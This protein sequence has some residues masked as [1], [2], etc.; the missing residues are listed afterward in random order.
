MDPPL[1]ADFKKNETVTLC[2]SHKTLRTY[3]RD[4][5]HK[6]G[7]IIDLKNVNDP[8][9]GSSGIQLRIQLKELLEGFR[10]HRIVRVDLQHWPRVKLPPEERLR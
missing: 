7:T 6:G 9:M 5:D 8:P 3:W 2:A 1:Y 10:R 4:H